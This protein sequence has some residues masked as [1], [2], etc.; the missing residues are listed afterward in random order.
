MTRLT[1]FPAWRFFAKCVPEW[2][3]FLREV[4]PSTLWASLHAVLMVA[5]TAIIAWS[6]WQQTKQTRVLSEQQTQLIAE[7]LRLAREIDDRQTRSTLTVATAGHLFAEFPSGETTE[8]VGVTVANASAFDVTITGWSVDVG[9][10]EESDSIRIIPWADPVA[11]FKGE[12][13]TDLVSLPRRLQQG[14]VARVLFRLKEMIALQ[15]RHQS[16]LR[17]AFRDS[18]GNTHRLPMWVEWTEGA[19]SFHDDPGSGLLAPE[20]KEAEGRRPQ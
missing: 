10:P 2:A 19:T 7:Q 18:W 4:G 1:V 9:I 11:E 14:D 17:I 3:S 20:E 12:Q 5:L 8:F 6:A 16:R 15:R 13:L